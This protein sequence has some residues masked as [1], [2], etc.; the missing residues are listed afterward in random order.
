MSRD[1]LKNWTIKVKVG[2]DDPA[3]D[4][5]R[6]ALIRETVGP[7]VELTADANIAWDAKTTLERLE[8]FD[9]GGIKLAYI[10]DPIPADQLEGYCLLA[11]EASR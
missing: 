5:A 1:V 7:E 10:E 4:I 6:L 3:R 2:A 11:R 9:A 8:A